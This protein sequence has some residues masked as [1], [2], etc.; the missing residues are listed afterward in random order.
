MFYFSKEDVATGC[1]KPHVFWT[2]LHS[3]C[4]PFGSKMCVL[5]L[6]AVQYGFILFYTL[7][8]VVLAQMTMEFGSGNFNIL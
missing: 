4:H 3:L 7:E 2:C 6:I 1:F 8:C 5:V